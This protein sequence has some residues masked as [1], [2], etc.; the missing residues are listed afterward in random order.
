MFENIGIK[1]ERDLLLGRGSGRAT[2]RPL[3]LG[4]EGFGEDLAGRTQ[5]SR[6]LGR[7]LGC[8]I[9]FKLD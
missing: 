1:P 3:E 7:Q 5:S 8:I 9:P 4:E 2:G 6:S